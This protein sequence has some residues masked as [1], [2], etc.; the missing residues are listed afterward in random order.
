MLLLIDTK[1]GFINQLLKSEVG[2]LFNNM[3]LLNEVSGA[4]NNWEQGFYDYG[5]NYKDKILSQIN[6]VLEQ[7][8]SPQC[9]LIPHSIGGGTGSGLG[10]YIVNILGEYYQDIFKFTLRLIPSKD[11]DVITSPHNSVLSL[12]HLIN[13]ADCVLT[14]DNESLIEIVNTVKSKNKKLR[15]I[16]LKKGK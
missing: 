3:Q 11:E 1:Q 2:E 7:C 16:F 15:K 6:T 12:N 8:D 9:F 4:G 10:S 14:V 5:T 13:N